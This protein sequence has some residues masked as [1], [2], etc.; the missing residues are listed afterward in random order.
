MKIWIPRL[1][2]ALILFS[3][4]DAQLSTVFAQGSLTPPSP[5]SPTMKTLDQVEA[6][7]PVDTNNT[8]GNVS[9]EFYINQPGSYYLT[10]NVVGVGSKNG[11]GIAANN[12]TLDLNGFLVQGVSSGVVSGIYTY[13]TCTNVIIRNGTINGW[14]RGINSFANTEV[15]EHL[16]VS[17]NLYGIQC[18]NNVAILDCT[19]NANSVYGIEVDGPGSLIS[20]NYFVGNDTEN[21]PGYAALYITSS[22]NRVENNHVTGSG[23]AGYG[24][25]IVGSSSVTNNIVIKNS[26]EGGGA[27]NYSI[28]TTYNDVGPIG[29]ASTNASP[30][31]NFSH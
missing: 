24:I 6:R 22:N 21:S 12:V 15:L 2:P 11:I 16:I 27:N 10:A 7:T 1:L 14:N 17:A 18:A 13:N 4:L 30:W 26:V 23:P 20:D 29:N 9:F 3:A 5:P 31:A 25:S 8:P 19:I 28:N